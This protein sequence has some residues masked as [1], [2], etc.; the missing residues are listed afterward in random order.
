MSCE[1]AKWPVRTVA[2]VTRSILFVHAHPDDESV[3]TGATM[4]YYAAA[5]AHVTLVTCTLG[6]EG[7]IHVPALSQ[8]AAPKADAPARGAPGSPTG[9]RAPN[10]EVR[11]PGGASPEGRVR[12]DHSG[13][14]AS[15]CARPLWSEDALSSSRAM[16]GGCVAVANR[17]D[18]PPF[19]G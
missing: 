6:E 2:H 9:S 15:C 3:G 1:P 10:A 13:S 16:L 8:L 4:A 11:T 18:R 12:A 5:G 14:G 17:Y 19:R 7:E